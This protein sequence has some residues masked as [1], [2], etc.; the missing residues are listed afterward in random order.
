ML[1]RLRACFT[2]DET[3]S[4]EVKGPA[5]GDASNKDVIGI[6]VGGPAF[7]VAQQRVADVVREGQSHLVSP[8]PRYLQRAAVPVDVGET[9]TRHISGAQ[10]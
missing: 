2:T 7:Q 10:S 9:E 5:R 8:F 1:A 6:N 4:P 3:P